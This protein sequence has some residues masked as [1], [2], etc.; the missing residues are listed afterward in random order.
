MLKS[1]FRVDLR[2]LILWMCLFFVILALGNSLHAAYQVQRSLLLQHHLDTNH[3]YAEKLARVTSSF[4]EHSAQAVTAAALDVTHSALDPIATQQELE[5]L[6]SITDSFNA[7]I[8]VDSTGKIFAAIAHNSSVAGASLVGTSLQTPQAR[9][10]L[11]VKNS[12]GISGAIMG[13]SGRWISFISHPIFAPDGSYAGFIAGAVHLHGSSALKNALDK[14]HYQDGSYFYIVDDSG[15]AVYH[16]QQSLIGTSFGDRPPVQAVLKGESR[17]QRVNHPESPD[18]FVSYMPIP[19]SKWGIVALRPT[20]LAISS[21]NELFLRTLYYSL[22]LFI[23]SLLAIWWLARFIAR[24]LRELANVAAHLDNRDN[25]AHIR[26]IKGWYLEAALIRKGLMQGFSAVS[27]R[28]RKLHL[29]GS[30]DPLTGVVNRRGLDTAIGRLTDTAQSTAVVMI[31]VDRFKDVNDKHGH[32]VGDE[33]L[34]TVTALIM[35]KARKED[36]VARMG[37]EEFVILLPDTELEQAKLFA[38]RLRLTVAQ[39]VFDSAGN[40]TV[41]L[42]VACFPQHAPSVQDAL[43]LADAALYRAKA[44]GRNCVETA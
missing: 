28:L 30:T 27:N 23:I 32:A 18:H 44:A 24:P 13:R 42:G 2:R 20:E 11:E 43:E 21:V 29:E 26:F 3:I 19:F 22:P 39:T 17:T 37:G 33:V 6:A 16:P 7:L 14:H 9:A 34:K 1:L 41:S 12:V 5:Q 38:E 40:I 10:L 35:A 25:F 31:D 4:F 15:S 36:V 8:A